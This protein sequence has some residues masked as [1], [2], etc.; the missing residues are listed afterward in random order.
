MVMHRKD[1]EAR[2]KTLEQ[3]LAQLSA[4][5]GLVCQNGRLHFSSQ[6]V[7][8]PSFNFMHGKEGAE[9]RSFGEIEA[10]DF[11]KGYHALR[12]KGVNQARLDLLSE[13]DILMQSGE[14]LHMNAPNIK[15]EAQRVDLDGELSARLCAT[16][17]Y[18]WQSG[19]PAVRLVHHSHGIPVLTE[20][21]GKFRNSSS[22]IRMYVDPEDGYWYL[23]GDGSKGANISARV[24]CMGRV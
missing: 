12:V 5:L 2:V 22:G 14:A 16:E 17:P 24:I 18:T 3:Q 4:V 11:G 6:G 23:T 9:A 13:R 15:I 19:Q 10:G 7:S 8:R 1:M 20:L 21:K